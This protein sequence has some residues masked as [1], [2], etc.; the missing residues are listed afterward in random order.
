M[1]ALALSALLALALSG[2]GDH[3]Q[4]PPR[5]ERWLGQEVYAIDDVDAGFRCYVA[6]AGST[7]GGVAIS[8][9][10]VSP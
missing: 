5:P 8:C 6:S 7:T 2:C 9:V 10:R 3:W 1:K 4:A